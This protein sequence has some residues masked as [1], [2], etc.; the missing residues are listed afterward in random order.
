[1][2]V[3]IIF[4]ELVYSRLLRLFVLVFEVVIKSFGSK[5]I[6]IRIFL[7]VILVALVVALVADALI[8]LLAISLRNIHLLSIGV[9]VELILCL[10]LMHMVHSRL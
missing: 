2:V 1:L 8:L 5:A 6:L 3:I 4:R 9:G 10:L 7:V